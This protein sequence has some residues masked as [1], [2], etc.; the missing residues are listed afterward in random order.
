MKAFFLVAIFA[1]A[2]LSARAVDLPPSFESQDLEGTTINYSSTVGT[3]AINIPTTADK[4]IS[5]VLFRCSLQTP[6]T[7]R[8]YISFDGTTYFTLIPGDIIGWSVK[9]RKKQIKINGNTTG[10][11]WEAVVNYESY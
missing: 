8:C 5:E 6:A 4:I 11:L 1:L 10:V 9:G 3:T 7:K 2:D